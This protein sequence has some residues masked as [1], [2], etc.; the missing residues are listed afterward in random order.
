M[1]A[2][3]DKE[4]DE[5]ASPIFG[6]E[7][8]RQGT[9]GRYFPDGK[10]MLCLDVA[11]ILDY[12]RDVLGHTLNDKPFI[13]RQPASSVPY[14]NERCN[15]AHGKRVE[16][17]L[18]T[19]TFERHGVTCKYCMTDLTYD[20]KGDRLKSVPTGPHQCHHICLSR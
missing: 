10:P 6:H 17:V 9:S 4:W 11:T 18:R 8:L 20:A 7:L 1:K 12:A 19:L 3:K 2:F 14:I 16:E 13:Q 5:Q 15:Q